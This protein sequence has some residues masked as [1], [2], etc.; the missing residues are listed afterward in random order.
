MNDTWEGI[1]GIIGIGVMIFVGVFLYQNFVN[2]PLTNVSG[3]VKYDDCREK[4]TLNQTEYSKQSGTFICNDTKT[5]SGKSMGGE[6]VKTVTDNA[7]QCQ[8]VYIYEKPAEEKCGT[9]EALRTDDKC[10]CDWGYVMSAGS[11]IS[12]TQNCQNTYGTNSYS[13]LDGTQ[14]YCGTGSFWNSDKTACVSQ[15]TLNQSCITAYGTGSYSTY[16]SN[17]K[18]ACDCSYGYSWNGQRNLCVTTESI[19]QICVRDIGKNS[20]YLGTVTGGKYNCS[21]SY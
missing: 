12:G 17:G 11:C 16:D 2:T 4:V 20:Y 9:N 19:N 15:D 21:P 3:I 13:S 10:Y 8:T 18:Q 14:C 6:C 1:S 7:G 5:N